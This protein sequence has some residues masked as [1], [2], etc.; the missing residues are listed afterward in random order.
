[1]LNDILTQKQNIWPF[2]QTEIES[3]CCGKKMTLAEARTCKSCASHMCDACPLFVEVS[4][5][6]I[7]CYLREYEVK[8]RENYLFVIFVFSFQWNSLTNNDF[9]PSEGQNNHVFF[10]IDFY[11]LSIRTFC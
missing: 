10:F 4:G 9:T 2:F 5:E 6:C 11:C 8:T 7:V 3:D 1:M